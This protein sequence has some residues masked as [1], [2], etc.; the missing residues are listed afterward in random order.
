MRTVQ[1][2]ARRGESSWC[3]ETRE[4]CEENECAGG[5]VYRQKADFSS[6]SGEELPH[7]KLPLFELRRKEASREPNKNIQFTAFIDRPDS[8]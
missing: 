4:F 6:G 1:D 2:L 3:F 5:T 8:V 7:N